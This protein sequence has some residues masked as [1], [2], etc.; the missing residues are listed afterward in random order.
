[1]N[2][3]IPARPTDGTTGVESR[4]LDPITV[5]LIQTR[6]TSIVREMRTVIIRTA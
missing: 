3:A 2:E 5:E 1:M 4:G 6:L